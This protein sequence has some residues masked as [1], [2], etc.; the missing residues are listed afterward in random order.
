[1]S[2][3]VSDDFPTDVRVNTGVKRR[4]VFKHITSGD[5]TEADLDDADN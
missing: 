1:M 3:W 5:E 2:E 4:L